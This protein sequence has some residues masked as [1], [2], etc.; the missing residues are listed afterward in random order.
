MV[1]VNPRAENYPIVARLSRFTGGLLKRE[2]SGAGCVNE[3]HTELTHTHNKYQ[4]A[5][6]PDQVG[7]DMRRNIR[8]KEKR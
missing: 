2:I 8:A 1:A 5:Q 6:E 4:P 7:G 3:F